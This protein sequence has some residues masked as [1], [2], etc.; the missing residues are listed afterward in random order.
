MR[1]F[2]TGIRDYITMLGTCGGLNRQ[3]EKDSP[4]ERN[5]L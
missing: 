4:K 5:K 3:K 2:S 1:Y